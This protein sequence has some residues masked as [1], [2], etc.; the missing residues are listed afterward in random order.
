VA[1]LHDRDLPAAR[2]FLR[3]ALRHKADHRTAVRWL[4]TFAPR[5]VLDLRRRVLKSF[6]QFLS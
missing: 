5:R 2:D 3:L 6:S 1:L 4:S